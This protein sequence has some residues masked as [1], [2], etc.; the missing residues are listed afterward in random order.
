MVGGEFEGAGGGGQVAAGEEGLG[1]HVRHR[2]QQQWVL[3][4]LGGRA[5]QVDQPRGQVQVAELEGHP[6]GGTQ[7]QGEQGCGVAA[8]GDVAELTGAGEFS[9]EVGHATGEVAVAGLQPV[10]AGAGDIAV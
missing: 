3:G 10:I 7:R 9:D 8:T 5:H 2:G 1:A 6:V 4:E